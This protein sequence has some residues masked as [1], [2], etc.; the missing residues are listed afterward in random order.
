MIWNLGGGR[1]RR[2]SI[3]CFLRHSVQVPEPSSIS[4]SD[5][6][7]VTIAFS[8]S[9][10]D[11]NVPFSTPVNAEALTGLA[12]ESPDLNAVNTATVLPALSPGSG[13]FESSHSGVDTSPQGRSSSGGT[14]PEVEDAS[15]A[16]GE[17]RKRSRSGDDEIPL[18]SGNAA[19]EMKRSDRV[20]RP[21]SPGLSYSKYFK[22]RSRKSRSCG[23]SSEIMIGTDFQA[24]LPNIC[25]YVEEEADSLCMWKPTELLSDEMIDE[26]LKEANKVTSGSRK[27]CNTEQF[28]SLLYHC[29]YNVN[30][31]LDSLRA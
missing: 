2:Y 24:V 9:S 11:Q 26:F 20:L 28:L 29:Q 8:D 12:S 14:K 16:V 19:E 15:P 30:V 18:F 21:R 31:A 17:A 7:D 6:E 10:N 25:T 1:R 23:C 3:K 27:Q 4:S 13:P 22:C 5:T